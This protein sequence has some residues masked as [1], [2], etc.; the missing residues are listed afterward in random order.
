MSSN[1]APVLSN[2]TSAAWPPGAPPVTLS[3]GTA[4]TPL[5]IGDI[6]SPNLAG[7]TVKLTNSTLL[8]DTLAVNLATS[9]G[10]FVGT[11]IAAVYNAGNFTL[12]LSGSDTQAN[13]EFV[14]QHVTFTSTNPA[15][16]RT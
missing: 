11:N 8:G 5:D 2:V 6:D 1:N 3:P 13:Y 12:T 14:L 16:V 9:G 4:P 10:F 15:P 7:A